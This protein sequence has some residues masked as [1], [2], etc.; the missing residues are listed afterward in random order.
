ME[1]HAWCPQEDDLL[2]NSQKSLSLILLLEGR[3]L[4]FPWFPGSPKDQSKIFQNQWHCLLQWVC[5]ITDAKC[6][7]LIS[8]YE[9]NES[10]ISY[11][12]GCQVKGIPNLVESDNKTQ[13]VVHY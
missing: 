3:L 13:Y 11:E 9:I 8:S 12:G 10:N 1:L 6:V 2:K 5:S 4:E 7:E